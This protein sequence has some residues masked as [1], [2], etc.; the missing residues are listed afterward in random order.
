[1]RLRNWLA[2][3]VGVALL[4][5][6]IWAFLNTP[7]RRAW[8]VGISLFLAV[9]ALLGAGLLVGVN[10]AGN[11]PRRNRYSWI[12]GTLLL[13][14]VLYWGAGI[15]HDRLW[16]LTNWLASAVALNAKRP[17]RPETLYQWV[18]GALRLF[19]WVVLPVLFLPLFARA[20]GVQTQPFWRCAAIYVALLLAGAVLP[21]YLVHW[22]PKIE[23]LWPQVASM[24]LRFG[25]AYLL[26][27]T[28]WSAL[29]RYIRVPAGR[30]DA[31]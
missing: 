22:V 7:D 10:L 23:G 29:G 11:V 8:Q 18:W 28:C 14:L 17:V 21:H 9:A 20:A 3:F 24:L 16:D 15:V 2:Q 25:I 31:M 12:L 4:A 19:E 30:P 5:A 27:I 13:L 26:L 1:M 6:L